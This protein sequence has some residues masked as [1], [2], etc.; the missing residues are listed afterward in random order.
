MSRYLKEARQY[1]LQSISSFTDQNCIS[2]A[3]GLHMEYLSTHLVA[4]EDL[5]QDVQI[6]QL[7]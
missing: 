7:I 4:S 5:N 2:I 6:R 3:N 1:R